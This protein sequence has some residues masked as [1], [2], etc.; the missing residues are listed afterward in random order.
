MAKGNPGAMQGRKPRASS[1]S[2]SYWQGDHE[3]GG[4][5]DKKAN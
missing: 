4:Q 2:S 3:E 5:E 1:R